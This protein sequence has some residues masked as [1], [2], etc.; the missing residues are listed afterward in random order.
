MIDKRLL[1]LFAALSMV[2]CQGSFGSGTALPGTANGPV[3]AAADNV[4]PPANTAGL[5]PPSSVPSA[6]ADTTIVALADASTGLRCPDVD[7]VGCILSFN[8]PAITATAAPTAVQTVAPTFSPSASPMQSPG[9]NASPTPTPTPVPGPSMTLVLTAAPKDAPPMVNRNPKAVATTALARVTLKPS[10]DF[11][12]NGLAVAT[13][14]LPPSQ[15]PGR[16]FALQL[17]EEKKKKKLPLYSLPKSQLDKD[18]NALT[19]TFKFPK[20]TLPKGHKYVLVLYGDELPPASETPQP[21]PSPSVT[22]S[23]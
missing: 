8:V 21:A 1:A 9:L 20:I 19:F 6:A 3:G 2:A 5:P 17:F 23:P 22:S 12:L 13:F 18:K 14:T 15:I 4:A 11:T 7:G 10:T 16:G